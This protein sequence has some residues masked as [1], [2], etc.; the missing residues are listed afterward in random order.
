MIKKIFVGVRRAWKFIWYGDSLLSY[1]AFFLFAIILLNI[2]YPIVFFVLSNTIGVNDV[3]AVVSG[4]MVHGSSVQ[5]TYY[6]YLNQIGISEE[7]IFSFPFT[8]GLNPG[9]LMV[10]WNAKA[11]EV[12]VGDVIVFDSQ[13]TLIIHRVIEKNFID[14]AWLFTTKGDHNTGSL[15]TEVNMTPERIVGVAKQKVPLLGIPKLI[16]TRFAGAVENVL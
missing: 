15:Y 4:S 10:V 7:K 12:N 14:D 5:T 13:G 8:T 6:D 2:T 3:V 16:L 1:I 11:E 9:D